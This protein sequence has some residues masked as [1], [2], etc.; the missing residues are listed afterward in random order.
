MLGLPVRLSETPGGIRAPAPEFGQ[1][2]EEVLMDV[3]GWD[4]DRISEL[5][6]KEVI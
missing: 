2:T 4:W 3:L 6:E 1:H 5:R